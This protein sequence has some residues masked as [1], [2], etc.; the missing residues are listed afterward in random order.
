M[1]NNDAHNALVRGALKALA[2]NGYCAW[3]T[4]TGAYKTDSGGFI[5][6]GKIG[7]GDITLILP[8]GGRHVECEAKTGTGRQSDNQKKHQKYV[9]EANGGIYIVFRSVPELL[10]I[11]AKIRC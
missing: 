2:I 6:Y 1:A 5:K 10:D 8:P 7:G 4:N 9:V 3:P 11:L